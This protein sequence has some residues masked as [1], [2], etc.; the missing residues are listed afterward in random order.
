[1]GKETNRSFRDI[2]REIFSSG[3]T[4]I[5]S[6]R[7]FGAMGF[8][9]CLGCLIFET[10][11]QGDQLPEGYEVTL[12][13][14]ASLLGLDSL[15]KVLARNPRNN[16]A[17]TNSNEYYSSYSNMSYENNRN[18]GRQTAPEFPETFD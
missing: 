9:I 11:N 14:C 13:T 15:A 1:M 3:A 16:K 4:T 8:M 7:V 12:I 18:S 17:Q 5:S 2:I 10:I 6:K